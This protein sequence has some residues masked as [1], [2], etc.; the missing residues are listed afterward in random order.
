VSDTVHSSVVE[1]FGVLG[2]QVTPL[3]VDCVTLIHHHSTLDSFTKTLAQ[4]VLPAWN[5]RVRVT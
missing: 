5:T 1:V 4:E 2:K 3:A